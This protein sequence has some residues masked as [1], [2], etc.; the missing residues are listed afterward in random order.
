M[1][2]VQQDAFAMKEL[3]EEGGDGLAGLARA[4]LEAGV[5]EMMSAQAD[6]AC[7]ATGTTRNGFRE[8]R[9]ET[10]VGTITLRIPKLRQ[11]TYFPDGLATAP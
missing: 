7:E 3:L 5:N 9:L 6:A 11:G 10:Q 1:D 8:R 4:L 2:T